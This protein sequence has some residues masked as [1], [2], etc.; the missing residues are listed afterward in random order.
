MNETKKVFISHASEDKERFVIPFATRLRNDGIDAW[1]D[2][3]EINPG[4]SLVE[5]IFDEGI[6]NAKAIVIVLSEYSIDK[7][8]VKQELE[9]SV[10]KRI[11][12]GTRLI[13]IVLDNCEVPL[14]L[15]ATVWKKIYNLADYEEEYKEIVNAIHGHYEKPSL[16]L[17]VDSQHREFF[18]FGGL[19]K[20]DSLVLQS[21]CEFLVK[22]VRNNISHNVVDLS[23]LENLEVLGFTNTEL[24]DSLE[25]LESE[26]Y[27]LLSRTL[28]NQRYNCSHFRVTT[29]GFDV[30]AR[31]HI[32]DYHE[33]FVRVASMIVNKNVT[34]NQGLKSLFDISLKT[35][36][37][38][39]DRLEEQEYLQLS[40]SMGG[41]VHIYN[42]KATLKRAL[43]S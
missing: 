23:V 13:P 4:D 22:D 38:I 5:K 32:T 24:S 42:V 34:T 11:D 35:I 41:L 30:Y 17:D 1:V 43:D 3:W 6:K 14:S 10:V 37:H 18:S 28:G 21:A 8:W 9:T 39:L 31:A 27:I 33:K 16:N 19:S 40:K 2:K 12:D 7:T 36:D 25:V 20:I 29:D 15:K 26:F